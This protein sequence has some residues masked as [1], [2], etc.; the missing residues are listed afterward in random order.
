MK[1]FICVSKFRRNCRSDRFPRWWILR[2]QFE[3]CKL[4]YSFCVFSRIFLFLFALDKTRF[5]QRLFFRIARDAR[6]S[7]FDFSNAVANTHYLERSLCLM[8]KPGDTVR[9]EFVRVAVS[10][11]RVFEVK[12]RET[13]SR[14][15]GSTKLLNACRYWNRNSRNSPEKTR[16]LIDTKESRYNLVII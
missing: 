2:L 3:T 6:S 4:S 9:Q 15:L 1:P 10:W 14:G 7:P 12:G 16:D 11:S 13:L 8:T 5:D